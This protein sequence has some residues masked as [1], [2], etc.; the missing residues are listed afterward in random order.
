MADFIQLSLYVLL[1]YQVFSCLLSYQVLLSFSY[2]LIYKGFAEFFY[3]CWA[4]KLSW[5]FHICWAALLWWSLFN[6]L[7]RRSFSDFSCFAELY[8]YLLNPQVLL[9]FEH[10]LSY[11]VLVSFI[12]LFWVKKIPD[13]FNILL[14][15]EHFQQ[16]SCQKNEFLASFAIGLSPSL[17]KENFALSSCHASIQH[18][19]LHGKKLAAAAK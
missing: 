16:C 14:S 17:Q 18:S 5:V 1:I 2:L 11:Q 13:C 8:S 6:F 7:E 9:S 3:I 4:T 10:L 15:F 19:L 12:K